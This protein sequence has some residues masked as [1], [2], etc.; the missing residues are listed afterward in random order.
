[1]INHKPVDYTIITE[2]PCEVYIIN[3]MDFLT[4][5]KKVLESFEEYI[6]PYPPDKE[7]RKMFCEVN[8]WKNFKNNLINIIKIDKLSKVD[9]FNALLRN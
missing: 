6:K 8:R 2:V 5:D 1:M 3:E 4:L 7:L 9:S